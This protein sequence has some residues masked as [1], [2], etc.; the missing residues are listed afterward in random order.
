MSERWLLSGAR[1]FLGSHAQRVV[2]S[3]GVEVVPL[4]RPPPG[5]PGGVVADLA[6]REPDLGGRSFDVIVHLASLVHHSATGAEFER[7][8]VGG[9]RNLLTAV[10]RSGRMPR[11]VIYASS[12][13][14]YGPVRGHLL[15][16]TTP[17]R[18]TSPYGGSK[19]RAEGIVEEWARRRGV[20]AAI[21][22]LPALVGSGMVGSLATLVAALERRT[23]VGLGSGSA[24]RSVVLA[25][26]VAA[27]L[28]RLSRVSGVFHLTDRAHPSFRE[29]ETAV[30]AHWGRRPP[31]RIPLPLA[32]LVARG[33]DLARRAGL[34]TR[35]SSETLAR[36]TTTLTFDDSRAVDRLDWSPRP[37]LENLESWLG[38]RGDDGR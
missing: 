28:P 16:E 11:A 14:V 22:R 27:A 32:G 21:L 38:R 19:R 23:Y 15:P 24:R 5:Q 17:L 12:I 25:A 20:A 33:A 18:A 36:A 35:F 34:A 6:Q 8:I 1:G 26:D 29:I 7:A 10:E 2:E 4:D 3:R 37:V 31:P 9:T 13:A 30:R